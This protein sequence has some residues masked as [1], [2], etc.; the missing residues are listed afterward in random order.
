[1][2]RI[3]K[4]AKVPSVLLKRGVAATADLKSAFESDPMSFTS[5]KGIPPKTIAKMQ[6]DASIYGDATVKKQLVLEQHGKCCYCEALF[7]DNGFGD[8]EHFR[9]KKGYQKHGKLG[10]TYPGYY[11]LAYEW[12]NLLFS[13]EVCNRR[14]KRNRFPLSEEPTRVVSLLST[15]RLE[16]EELL[17]IDPLDPI[18]P[19]SEFLS[20]SKE[21]PVP[22]NDSQ[23]GAVSINVYGLE[24]MNESRREYLNILH[25]LLPL[26]TID[27]NNKKEVADAARATFKGMDPSALADSIRKAKAVLNNAAKPTAKF[28]LCVGIEFP[29]LPKH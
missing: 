15:N 8:V 20:F 19:P 23:K 25:G 1:M 7:T 2:I 28:S 26:T 9:P 27:E 17:L 11:W 21:V 14:F 18:H 5:R 3:W 12:Q 13:C 22:L 10:L 16:D 29:E 4:T 24:R 6:F